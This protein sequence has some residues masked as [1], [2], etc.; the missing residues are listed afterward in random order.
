LRIVLLLKNLETKSIQELAFDRM[1]LLFGRSRIC[2]VTIAD[3]SLSRQQCNLEL[4]DN[5]K[6]KLVDLNSANGTLFNGQR[7]TEQYLDVGQSFTIGATEIRIAKLDLAEEETTLEDL[8]IEKSAS[9]QGAT[10]LKAVPSAQPS[11]KTD[12]KSEKKSADLTMKTPA[13]LR[14][15]TTAL[16]KT[17]DW[18]QVSLLWKGELVDIQCFDQG[19]IVT[20]GGSASNN[21]IVNVPSLPEKFQFL[22]ILNNGVEVQLHPSMKGMVETRNS[23]RNLEDLRA[24]ARQTEIGL[25]TFVQ[26]SDR[27]LFEVGPFALYIQSVRLNLSAPLTAPLIR[28]PIFAGILSFVTLFMMGF[29]FF[30]GQLTPAVEEE[31]KVDEPVVTLAPP[32]EKFKAPPPPPP[33]PPPKPKSVEKGPKAVKKQNLSGSQGEGARS[34]G[35]EGKTGRTAG[36]VHA[37]A[38]PIG[39]VSKPQPVRS[40]PKGALGDVKDPNQARK[41][42]RPD[43]GIG[44]GTPKPKGTGTQAPSKD[45]KPN[46]KVEDMGVLGV[47]SKNEGGGGRAAGG[48][49]LSGKGLGGEIEGSLEGLERGS[50][51]DAKGA[52]GRGA[53]GLGLGGGGSSIEVGGLKTKGKGGGQSGFGLGS[54]GKKGEAEVS[55]SVEEVEV[56]DGLTR[57]EI[58]R[59]VRAHQSEIQ[60]CYEKALIQSGNQNL[61]G[62]LKARWFINLNGTSENTR[63]ESGVSDGGYLFNCV[64]QRIRTWQFPRP[65]GGKGVEVSWPW[66]FRKGG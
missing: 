52:G 10:K 36:T 54:S 8:V 48:G 41:G 30:V 18:V 4:K 29:F 26:F 25:A 16:Y 2:D 9:L 31:K 34:Q 42:I 33:P 21:F 24:T 39:I 23:V 14:Q 66:V 44:S 27:C 64:S 49:V 3:P 50:D 6:L 61:G 40:A 15:K 46:V 45:L 62:R 53:K 55:Y 58:E 12:K 43:Q 56:Q 20:I 59:V 7:I 28:E 35:A 32:E 63:E 57:E 17:K 38:R 11:K 51:L 19:D 5:S 37:K 65:R 13:V 1:P 22:K 60:A 47:L